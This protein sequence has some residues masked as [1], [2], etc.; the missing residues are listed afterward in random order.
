MPILQDAVKPLETDEEAYK[1]KTELYSIALMSLTA[2]NM[3]FSL[4][5]IETKD[6]FKENNNFVACEEQKISESTLLQ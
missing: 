2:D 3:I 5:P 4:K 1:R 6:E